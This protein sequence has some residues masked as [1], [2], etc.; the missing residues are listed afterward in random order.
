MMNDNALKV[1]QSHTSVVVLDKSGEFFFILILGHPFRVHLALL[2]EPRAEFLLFSKDAGVD[3]SRTSSSVMIRISN[4]LGF[5]NGA[6]FAPLATQRSSRSHPVFLPFS[7]LPLETH[8][9][10]R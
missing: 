7:L 1:Y 2:N 10:I 9:Q 4:V 8:T 6:I 5:V 3:G